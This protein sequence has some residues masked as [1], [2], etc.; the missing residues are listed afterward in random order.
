M[1]AFGAL[2]VAL[3]LALALGIVRVATGRTVVIIVITSSIESTE[4]GR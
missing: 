4:A 1:L 3:I 2:L